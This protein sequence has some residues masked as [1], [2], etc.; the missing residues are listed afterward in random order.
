MGLQNAK[1]KKYKT[2]LGNTQLSTSVVSRIMFAVGL[3]RSCRLLK[4]QNQ[5]SHRL[6]GVDT[7]TVRSPVTK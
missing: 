5:G 2:L 1:Y 6:T 7:R 4:R 3:L